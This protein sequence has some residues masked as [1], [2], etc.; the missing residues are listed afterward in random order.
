MVITAIMV[1]GQVLIIFVGGAAFQVTPLWGWE[2][3]ASIGLGAASLPVGV[4]IRMLPDAWFAAIGEGLSSIWR[5]LVGLLPKRWRTA[6]ATSPDAEQQAV[7]EGEAPPRLPQRTTSS[8]NPYRT[9]SFVRGG[10]TTRSIGFRT[11]LSEK[12]EAFGDKLKSA[13][14]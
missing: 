6:G 13:S 3:G 8:R 10:R 4:F 9:M 2:W 14:A 7:E 5:R 11:W 1:G 12:K